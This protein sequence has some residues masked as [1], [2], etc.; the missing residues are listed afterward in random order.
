MSDR[1]FAK[2][3]VVRD[4]YT[5]VINKGSE[6][7]V[8]EGDKFLLV[9]VGEVITDPDTGEE[10]EHLELVRGKAT[11]THVQNRVTTLESCEYKKSSDTREI[12][13]VTTK[14]TA[15]LGMLGPQDTVTESIKPGE[16][17]LMEFDG[18]TK[19]DFVIKL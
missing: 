8:K 4:N 13:K 19:G 18:A 16:S 1:Y 2:V 3:A 17:R 7:G 11:A 12:K 15:L 14:A 9:G 6:S 10:L 5:V